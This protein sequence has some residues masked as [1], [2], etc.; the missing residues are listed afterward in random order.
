ML[1]QNFIL[2]NVASIVACLA[3]LRESKML[4]EKSL[5]KSPVDL[6][7]LFKK[8]PL[9]AA[10]AIVL[11]GCKKDEDPVVQHDTTYTFN[12]NDG[13]NISPNKIKASAD[14]VEVRYI[15]LVPTGHF[16]NFIS[17]NVTYMITNNLKPAIAAAKGK[18]KGKGNFEFNPEVATTTDST[19][20][21]KQG[22]TVNDGR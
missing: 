16:R 1:K 5:E 11:A 3:V 2:R 12:K 4:K 18:G 19:W 6:N 13:S 21:V 17:H 9:V 22:W 14:S 15:Y 10:A 8:L 7:R 20:L